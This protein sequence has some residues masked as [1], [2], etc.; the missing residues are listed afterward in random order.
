MLFVPY[1]QTQKASPVNGSEIREK[2]DFQEKDDYC[3]AINFMSYSGENST[4]SE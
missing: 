1:I 2:F 3:E 4:L